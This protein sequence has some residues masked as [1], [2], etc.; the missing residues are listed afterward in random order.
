MTTQFKRGELRGHKRFWSY[1]PPKADGSRTEVWVSNDEYHRRTQLNREI[2][3]K[4]YAEG[5][6]YARH[7]ERV[8]ER[9]HNQDQRIKL[10][11]SAKARAKD[12][13]LPFTIT[14]EDIPQVTHCPVFGIE[15]VQGLQPDGCRDAWSTLDEIKHGKGYVPGNV[16]VVSHLANLIKNKATI[17]QLVQVARFYE[18]IGAD[19]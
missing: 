10:W 4:M 2:T 6:Y 19:E 5:T 7:R 18:L 12:K 8:L 11:Q 3:R 9:Y 14:I 15:F 16:V 13:G 1:R 17:E